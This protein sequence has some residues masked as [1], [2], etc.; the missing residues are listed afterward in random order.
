[1]AEKRNYKREAALE[2]PAR[3]AA[4]AQRNRARRM[5]ANEG[6]VHVGD[7]KDVGHKTAIGRGGKNS[8]SNLFVQDPHAN[9]SFDRNSKHK[10]VS[11]ISPSEKKGKKK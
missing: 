9:R 3:K 4:R 2:T 10:M 5:L 11:E 8:L 7:G 6:K 1:M